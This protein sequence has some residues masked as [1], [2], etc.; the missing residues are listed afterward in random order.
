LETW[1]PIVSE[2]QCGKVIDGGANISL[3][4]RELTGNDKASEPGV[5]FDSSVLGDEASK[6]VP[7]GEFSELRYLSGPTLE[8]MQSAPTADGVDSNAQ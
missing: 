7:L 3:E 8:A 5:H 1:Q 2:W 4:M 6:E